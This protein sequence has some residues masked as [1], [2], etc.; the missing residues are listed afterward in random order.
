LLDRRRFKTQAEAELAV[1]A[2]W[3]QARSIS[4]HPDPAASVR[5]LVQALVAQDDH[6]PAHEPAARLIRVLCVDERKPKS[7]AARDPLAAARSG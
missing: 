3:L 6:R 2:S 7:K 5:Q 1:F 4:M